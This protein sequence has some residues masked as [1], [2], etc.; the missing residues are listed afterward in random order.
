QRPTRRSNAT[1][2]A[3]APSA[4][5]RRRVKNC[6]SRSTRSPRSAASW[7]LL[8]SQQPVI[9]MPPHNRIADFVETYTRDLKAEDL[10]RLFTR[11][12][13]EDRKSTRLNSSHQI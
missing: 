3:C 1:K 8:R 5:R 9:E 12:A 6:S 4:P 7:E 13:R 10:Q 11:D 2:R